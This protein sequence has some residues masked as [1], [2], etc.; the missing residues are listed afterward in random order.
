MAAATPATVPAPTPDSIQKIDA[1]VTQAV[2]FEPLVATI[3]STLGG[4]DI[5]KFM[6]YVAILHVGLQTV[7]SLIHGGAS[8]ETALQQVGDALITIGTTLKKGTL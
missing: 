8:N 5:G 4:P 3:V 1:A 2:G 7:E 6:P